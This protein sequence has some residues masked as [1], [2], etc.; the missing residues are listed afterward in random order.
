MERLK[1]LSKPPARRLSRN[2]ETESSDVDATLRSRRKVGN[3]HIFMYLHNLLM[4]NLL[5][6]LEERF[7][8]NQAVA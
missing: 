3:I 2:S 5:F 7:F 1:E 8:G 4:N 6:I